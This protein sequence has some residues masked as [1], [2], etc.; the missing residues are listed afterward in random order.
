MLRTVTI[1]HV[2]AILCL[3]IAIHTAHFSAFAWGAEQGMSADAFEQ[4]NRACA[5]G[6]YDE[7]L[8]WYEQAE[9]EKGL[10]AALLYNR[11]NAYYHKK[12][13][14]R[15]ILSYERALLLEPGNADIRANLALARQDFGLYD[16][17]APWWRTATSVVSLNQWTWLASAALSVFSFLLLVR[18]VAIAAGRRNAGLLR[19]FGAVTLCCAALFFTAAG[20]LALGIHAVDRAVVLGHDVRLLVSPFDTAAQSAPLCQG[21][22][23]AIQKTHGDY[24]LIQ[25]AVGN[26][27]W[28]EQSALAPIVPADAQG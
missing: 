6:K 2:I 4:G 10:S 18:G 15:C 20:G 8:T 5:A 11:G 17:P 16:P 7:A 21:R 12:E 24:A 9:K 19:Y 14:G 28:V 27:G 22:T 1:K 25:D 13:I 23:V 26:S 3:C